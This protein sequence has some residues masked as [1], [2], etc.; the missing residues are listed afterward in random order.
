M[1]AFRKQFVICAC[2]SVRTHFSFLFL[3]VRVDQFFFGLR[4]FLIFFFFS[5]GRTLSDRIHDRDIKKKTNWQK[6]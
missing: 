4:F 3:I 1:S 5:T 6:S 2:V